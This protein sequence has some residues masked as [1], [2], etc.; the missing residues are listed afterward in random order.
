MFS[1]ATEHIPHYFP[2]IWTEGLGSYFK[3]RDRIIKVL[4]DLTRTESI[5]KGVPI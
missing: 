4:S 3:L 1:D 2:Q 5:K